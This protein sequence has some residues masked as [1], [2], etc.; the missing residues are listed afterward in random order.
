MKAAVKDCGSDPSVLCLDMLC[1][2]RN[3]CVQGSALPSPA[4]ALSREAEGFSAVGVG[5]GLEEGGER[6]KRREKNKTKQIYWLCRGSPDTLGHCF[7]PEKSATPCWKP[8]SSNCQSGLACKT[9]HSEIPTTSQP[10]ARHGFNSAPRGLLHSKAVL[11]QL[12]P[13]AAAALHTPTPLHR[14]PPGPGGASTLHRSGGTSSTRVLMHGSAVEPPGS[15]G[16]E[17]GVGEVTLGRL[18]PSWASSG[19]WVCPGGAAL[20]GWT[21]MGLQWNAGKRVPEEEGR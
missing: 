6:E 11:L 4:H 20:P 10:A 14:N 21:T 18:S 17:E 2:Q 3:C 15:L 7:T 12:Q 16:M 5:P 1:I 13:R 8:P 9:P 19:P